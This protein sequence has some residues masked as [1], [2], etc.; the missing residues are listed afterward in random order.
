MCNPDWSPWRLYFNRTAVATCVY[1]CPDI[2][3]GDFTRDELYR[4]FAFVN[5]M[6]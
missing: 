1:A 2:G 3:L 6:G 5:E 4:W